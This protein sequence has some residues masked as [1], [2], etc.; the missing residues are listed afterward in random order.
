[1]SFLEGAKIK[2]SDHA[3]KDFLNGPLVHRG[4]RHAGRLD[5]TARGHS[6]P[7]PLEFGDSF[8]VLFQNLAVLF[9]DLRAGLVKKLFDFAAVAEGFLDGVNQG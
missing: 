3:G 1:M 6:C 9:E 2:R 4:T 5:L 7:M 8:W